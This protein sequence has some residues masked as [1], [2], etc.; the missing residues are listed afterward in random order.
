MLNSWVYVGITLFR[1]PLAPYISPLRAAACP[2]YHWRL[3]KNCSKSLRVLLQ[4]TVHLCEG[5]GWDVD[6]ETSVILSSRSSVMLETFA[7]LQMKEGEASPWKWVGASLSLCCG[8]SCPVTL[9]TEGLSHW[10][11]VSVT[12]FTSSKELLVLRH[13][14]SIKGE[15]P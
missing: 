2:S 12:S 14:M 13:N 1:A 8:L 10:T 4:A 5:A 7:W 6:G 3:L 9:C 11:S 15:L